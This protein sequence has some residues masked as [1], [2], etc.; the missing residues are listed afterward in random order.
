MDKVVLYTELSMQNDAKK[1]VKIRSEKHILL[2]GSL[3]LWFCYER[4]LM[5]AT[6]KPSY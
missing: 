4:I 6:F 1:S 5:H 3:L 2:A